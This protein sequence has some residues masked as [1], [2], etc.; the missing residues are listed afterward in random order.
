VFL[1]SLKNPISADIRLFAVAYFQEQLKLGDVPTVEAM[2]DGI[3]LDGSGTNPHQVLPDLDAH[4]AEYQ[5]ANLPYDATKEDWSFKGLGLQDD[6]LPLLYPDSTLTEAEYNALIADPDQPDPTTSTTHA[7]YKK[8][9]KLIKEATD[10]LCSC[11]DRAKRPGCHHNIRVFHPTVPSPAGTRC[12][13]GANRRH[14][15][16]CYREFTYTQ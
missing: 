10:V 2:D 15:S 7:P 16:K 12:R 4:S 8:S 5:S 14:Q 6:N 3:A 11:V 9:M 1:L 13:Y